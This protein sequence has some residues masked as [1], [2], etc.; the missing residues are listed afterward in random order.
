MDELPVSFMYRTIAIPQRFRLRLAFHPEVPGKLEFSMH[1]AW[2]GK[3]GNVIGDKDDAVVFP[4]NSSF[5]HRSG[6]DNAR[7]LAVL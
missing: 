1:S 5:Q 4:L 6:H 3:K 7:A 2:I